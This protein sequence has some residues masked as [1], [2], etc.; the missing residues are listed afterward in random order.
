MM[1]LKSDLSGSLINSILVQLNKECLESREI[2]GA[3]NSFVGD[4]DAGKLQGPAYAAVKE[5][6]SLYIPILEKR[7]ELASEMDKSIR[8]A[9][10]IM[11]EYMGDDSFLDDADLDDL[12]SSLSSA[13][14]SL[15]SLMSVS[16]LTDEIKNS[17]W[18]LQERVD[19]LK[20]EIEKLELLQ[21]TDSAAYSNVSGVQGNLSGYQTLVSGVSNNKISIPIGG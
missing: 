11:N 9:L 12:R 6:V 5:R 10:N 7:I 20:K 14:A 4:I 21:P 13:E 16:D 3:I 15:Q 2:I 17:V 19:E 18:A 1:I 8:T